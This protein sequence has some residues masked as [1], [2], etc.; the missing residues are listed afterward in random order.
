MF[1]SRIYS[2]GEELRQEK[3]HKIFKNG[4]AGSYIGSERGKDESV[5]CC[6]QIQHSSVHPL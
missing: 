4:F 1:M 2:Y 5:G 3:A 6:H